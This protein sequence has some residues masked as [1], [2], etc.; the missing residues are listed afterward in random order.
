MVYA[1][2]RWFMRTMTRGFLF[3]LFRIVDEEYVPRTGPALICPNHSAN[4]DPP[5]VPAF[6]PRGDSWNM[7][8]SEYFSGSFSWLFRAYHAFPVVRHSADRTALRKAFDLLKSGQVL[9]MYPEGTRGE[10]GA[11]REPEAGAGFIA[12]KSEAPVVPVA[13]TGTRECLPKGARWPRRVPV[14]MRYGKPFVIAQRKADG[15]RVT[16][17]E[18]ADAIMCAIAEMLPPE[19]RGVYSDFEARR[20][21]LAGVTEP[22][23]AR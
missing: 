10:T 20:V 23:V 11:L 4:L 21:R 5:L 12:Q 19:M 16:R 2:L 18:A 9:I 13:M 22:V 14:T 1:F 3:G 8:K 6:L 17:E 7:A 15:T